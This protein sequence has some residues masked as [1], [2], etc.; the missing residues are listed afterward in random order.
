MDI[1]TVGGI[2]SH[3]PLRCFLMTSH[4]KFKLWFVWEGYVAWIS[5]GNTRR[6]A[7]ESALRQLSFVLHP[8]KQSSNKFQTLNGGSVFSNSSFE[9]GMLVVHGSSG[10]HGFDAEALRQFDEAVASVTDRKT[11]QQAIWCKIYTHQRRCFPINVPGIKKMA[12]W[13]MGPLEVCPQ[14]GFKSKARMLLVL[15]DFGGT[16]VWNSWKGV[17]RDSSKNN[18]MKYMYVVVYMNIYNIY[19]IICM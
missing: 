6:L 13:K 1:G 15:D 12:G 7:W 3:S 19:Y 4:V 18:M 17:F 2:S 9:Y 14:F 8:S 11:H 5:L 16:R 10:W